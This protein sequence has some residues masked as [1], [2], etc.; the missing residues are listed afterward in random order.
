VRAPMLELTDEEKTAIR[1]A[2]EQ[3]GLEV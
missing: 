2:F 1:E 3:C